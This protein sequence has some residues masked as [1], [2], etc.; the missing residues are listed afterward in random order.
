[1]KNIFNDEMNSMNNGSLSMLIGFA[2]GVGMTSIIVKIHALRRDIIIAE[3][4]KKI[5]DEL[6]NDIKN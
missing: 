2:I 1:M 6:M 3:Q 4:S 5:V